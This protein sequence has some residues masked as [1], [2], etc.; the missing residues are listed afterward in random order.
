MDDG[1]KKVV[2][3]PFK[4]GNKLSKGRPRTSMEVKHIQQLTRDNVVKTMNNLAG[5]N[6]QELEEV[7]KDK[8]K[9][10]H[11]L[12]LAKV[13]VEAIKRGDNQRIEWLYQRTMGKMREEV[14]HTVTHTLHDQFMNYLT[15]RDAPKEEEIERLVGPETKQEE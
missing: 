12:M 4:K 1:V 14:N 10:V 9:T 7:L 8:T 15:N 13:I 2:G 6:I 11:E 3:R 5:L